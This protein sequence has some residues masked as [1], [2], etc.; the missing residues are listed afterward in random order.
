MSEQFSL[1]KHRFE[2][3]LGLHFFDS[4]HRDPND[5]P[6]RK[7]NSSKHDRKK[8]NPRNFNCLIKLGL[9]FAGREAKT[10]QMNELVCWRGKLNWIMHN[11]NEFQVLS[12]SQFYE[13]TRIDLHQTF[14]LENNSGNSIFLVFVFLGRSRQFCDSN[15]CFHSNNV[16]NCRKESRHRHPASLLF[17]PQSHKFIY[18]RLEE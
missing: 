6:P 16:K 7:N 10:R 8:R 2:D 17:P 9:R 12:G 4:S 15:S 5:L 14:P 18:F 3:S 11:L 13:L 1:S